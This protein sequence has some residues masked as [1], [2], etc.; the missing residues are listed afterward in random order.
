MYRV[1]GDGNTGDAK[2]G[3]DDDWCDLADESDEEWKKNLSKNLRECRAKPFG[4]GFTSAAI[5]VLELQLEK[6]R[7]AEPN[8]RASG[9]L[10]R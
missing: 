5:L 8:G 10:R 6:E 9:S 1:D 4:G 3:H 2:D 7:G